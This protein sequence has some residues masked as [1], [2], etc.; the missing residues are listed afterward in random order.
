MIEKDCSS[1]SPQIWGE[2]TW[3][4]RGL[5]PAIS[6]QT[7]ACYNSVQKCRSDDPGA[8]SM[9]YSQYAPKKDPM[10]LAAPMARNS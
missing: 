9:Y 10:A 2:L 6:R 4:L 3:P 7:G 5:T 1:Y 8:C